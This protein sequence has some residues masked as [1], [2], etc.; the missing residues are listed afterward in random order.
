MLLQADIEAT[1]LEFL[2]F[3]FY[4]NK[5]GKAEEWYEKL[6]ISDSS[7]CLILNPIQ[8]RRRTVFPVHLSRV[9]L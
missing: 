8:G 6:K 9:D 1:I 3:A 7:I 4:L 2:P 5:E